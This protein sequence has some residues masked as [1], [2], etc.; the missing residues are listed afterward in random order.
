MGVSSMTEIGKNGYALIQRGLIGN[1][2]FRG[3]DDEYAAMWLILHAAYKPLTVR[4]G[5]HPVTLARGEC[6][7]SVS[8]LAQAW[9]C[10]KS[11]AHATLKHL[12]KNQFLTMT[13]ERGFT[14]ICLTNYSTYQLSESDARTPARTMPER[15]FSKIEKTDDKNSDFSERQPERE[16]L[17]KTDCYGG[18]TG[19]TRTQGRTP[20][21]R[22]PNASRT[23]KNTVNTIN[24]NNAPSRYRFEGKVV[25][26]THEDFA[27]WEHSFPNLDIQAECQS[28]DDWAQS[29]PEDERKG[30]FHRLSGVLRKHNVEAKPKQPPKRNVPD[31]F[32][33][34]LYGIGVGNA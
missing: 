2:Q 31:H 33:P 32:D 29:Q 20:P 24:K 18:I 25:R 12:E 14:R 4:V 17:V 19:D 23:N 21:E 34:D 5:R 22:E 8:F 30:W 16:T 15:E 7:Y 27:K 3:K 9:E 10:S 11:T 28:Y 1:P 13:A 26:L 6:A